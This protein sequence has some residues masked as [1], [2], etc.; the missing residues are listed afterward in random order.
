MEL[1]IVT[2]ANSEIAKQ[3]QHGFNH[4]RRGED[5]AVVCDALF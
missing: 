2:F 5:L 1:L 4:P 3:L